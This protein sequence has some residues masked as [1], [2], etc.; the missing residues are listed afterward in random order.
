M[1]T[2]GVAV[3]ASTAAPSSSAASRQPAA[4]ASGPGRA[5][6]ADARLGRFGERPGS[7][8]GHRRVTRG[9]RVYGASGMSSGAFPSQ[10]DDGDAELAQGEADRLLLHAPDPLGG[11]VG[12]PAAGRRPAL[13]TSITIS[14]KPRSRISRSA[15]T[16]RPSSSGENATTRDPGREGGAG[17][18]A[19]HG[20]AGVT[21]VGLSSTSMIL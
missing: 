5:L 18:P 11:R 17:Q 10:G 14:E 21:G 13:S 2:S 15:S 16:K 3:Q 20:A 4:E 12:E 6:A 1:C 19:E 9:R 7:A 8:G